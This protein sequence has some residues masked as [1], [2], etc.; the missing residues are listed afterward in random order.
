MTSARLERARPW[1]GTTVAVR[2]FGRDDT[3]ERALEA[4]F[5]AIEAVHRS[6]SFHDAASDLSRINRDAFDAPQRV[7]APLSRVLRAS[8]ALASASA[9]IFDP[10]VAARL[11][12]SGHLPRPDAREP[13]PYADWRDVHIDA[14]GDVRFRK[15]LWLDLGGIA[16]GFA[17]DRAVD[18]ARRVGAFAGVVNAGGDL[19]VFGDAPETVSVRD[20]RDPTRAIELA[21]VRDAALATSAGYFSDQKGQTALVDTARGQTMPPTRSVTVVA[22]RAMWADALTKVVLASEGRSTPLLRRL[23][24]HAAL[25]DAD[26]SVRTWP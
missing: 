6:M 10:T 24:A 18:A 19:R 12:A 5:A 20:P 23:R 11:V 15:P 7:P 9:G 1:L 2:I 21:T 13:D 26:G 3:V 4:A 22:P 17:V 8:L 25:I 16:K 14:R